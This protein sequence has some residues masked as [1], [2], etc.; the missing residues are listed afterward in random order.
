MIGLNFRLAIHATR[1]KVTETG[2]S[3]KPQQN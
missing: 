3:K 2:G 1:V